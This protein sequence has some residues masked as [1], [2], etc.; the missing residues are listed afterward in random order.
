MIILK[1]QKPAFI[2]NESHDKWIGPFL[3]PHHHLGHVSRKNIVVRK[4]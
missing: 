2:V 4:K 1:Y 3:P